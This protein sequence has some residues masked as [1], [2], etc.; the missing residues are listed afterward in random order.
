MTG[1]FDKSAYDQTYAKEHV[2]MKR[3]PFN[4]ERDAALLSALDAQ[5]EPFATYVKRLIRED[6]ERRKVLQKR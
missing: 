6:M 1:E 3:V 4:R 2:V 5:Q